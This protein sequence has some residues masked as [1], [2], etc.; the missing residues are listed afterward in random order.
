MT[1]KENICDKLR[2]ENYSLEHYGLNEECKNIFVSIM[3]MDLPL[4]EKLELIEYTVQQSEEI[5]LEKLNELLYLEKSQNKFNPT[6]I[7]NNSQYQTTE[8]LVH[9][10]RMNGMFLKYLE[11]N[12]Y[13]SREE[14]QEELSIEAVFSNAM[15]LK[16][17]KDQNFFV[18]YEAVMVNPFALIYVKNK[19]REL[20]LA[21]VE[22]HG[23]IL[24]LID[25]N[26]ITKEICVEAI[27]HMPSALKFLEDQK[28]YD[29]SLFISLAKVNGYVLEYVEDKTPNI[30]LAA[31][32]NKGLALK[33]VEKKLQTP[34]I[35]LAAVNENGRALEY[36]KVQTEEICLAA[37]LNDESAFEF[38]KNQTPEICS[39]AVK[40]NGGNLSLVEEQTS[41]MCWDAIE[42]D[43][44]NI[45]YVKHPTSKMKSYCAYGTKRV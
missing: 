24:G 41:E 1:I 11:Q 38:V 7:I 17:V 10:V 2:S 12:V 29:E 31:V 40:R 13:D 21:A 20:Y 39:Q 15:A 37:V 44:V 36:V 33:F 18:C 43:V 19:T 25:G 28:E 26:D 14:N 8:I 23:S 45:E 5:Y 35:C 27:R 30:C 9:A 6:M 32:M 22:G 42:Q 3:E 34:K 4:D 16:Y